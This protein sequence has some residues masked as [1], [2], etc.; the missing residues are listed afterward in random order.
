MATPKASAKT[1]AKVEELLA[2]G[3]PG[4]DTILDLTLR[5]DLSDSLVWLALR[6]LEEQGK[7][8]RQRRTA[9]LWFPVEPTE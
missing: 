4:G 1:I 6:E 5:S 3:E 8:R 7:A 2:G 9:D